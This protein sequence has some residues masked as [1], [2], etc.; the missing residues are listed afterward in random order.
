MNK[1]NLNKPLDNFNIYVCFSILAA[2][3]ISKTISTQSV[4]IMKKGL[5]V[6]NIKCKLLKNICILNQIKLIITCVTCF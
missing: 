2:P 5:L 3:F 6:F 4:K 1:K